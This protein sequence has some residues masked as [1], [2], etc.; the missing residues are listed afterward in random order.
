MLWFGSSA[1]VALSALFPEARSVRT[2]LT[3]GWHVAAGYVI[4]FAVLLLVL[5]WHLD[6]EI[7]RSNPASSNVSRISAP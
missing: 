1:G 5:G 4:G 6:A 7:M 2:W 3:N